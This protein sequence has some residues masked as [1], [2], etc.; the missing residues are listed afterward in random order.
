MSKG[1]ITR[2][3]GTD[4]KAILGSEGLATINNLE[5]LAMKV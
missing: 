3:S 4:G 5:K 2:P 1:K